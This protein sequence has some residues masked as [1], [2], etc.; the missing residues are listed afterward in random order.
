M[1][2]AARSGSASSYRYTF[3]GM[4]QD[5][6]VSGQ[7]NSYTTMFR[8]YDP[9]LGR[10]KSLDPLMSMFPD[11]SPYVGFG[12]NPIYYTDPMGLA[13]V[14][15]S[16]SVDEPPKY[17]KRKFGIKRGKKKKRKFYSKRNK[18]G[19]KKRFRS[20]GFRKVLRA[21]FRTPKSKSG[22]RHFTIGN[23]SISTRKSKYTWTNIRRRSSF[24][25]KSK[26]V[27]QTYQGTQWQTRIF[28]SG[29]P[30]S[31]LWDPANGAP[32]RTIIHPNL[33]IGNMSNPTG[34]TVAS[35]INSPLIVP[36]S[37]SNSRLRITVQLND[38]GGTNRTSLFSG[39]R[40][41][42]TGGSW[43]VPSFS[44][45]KRSF[46]VFSILNA[47]TIQTSS[48]RDRFDQCHGFTAR[49]TLRYQTRVTKRRLVRVP[50]YDRRK[51][52]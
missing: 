38:A 43:L 48:V 41:L 50:V 35:L 47:Q 22:M 20:K 36:G 13:P 10:W 40:R 49:I 4:E 24:T 26:L 32:R 25:Q 7:G 30:N 2:I 28:S 15:S 46:S 52:F 12:N 23:S 51:N 1:Q 45:A 6:A 19:K 18:R 39:T 17:S 42:G 33:V 9:R 3:N 27:W 44:I 14:S 21:L 11:Q 37:I 8:Q 34:G 5:G 31:G 16:T 29:P